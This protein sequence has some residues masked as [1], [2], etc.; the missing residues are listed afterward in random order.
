MG[1]SKPKI[2]IE[3]DPYLSIAAMDEEGARK[4]AISLGVKPDDIALVED[5]GPAGPKWKRGA[6]LFYVWD[7]KP[8]RPKRC[9]VCDDGA[10]ETKSKRC[11]K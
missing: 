10:C 4:T 3:R 11:G 6:R 7:S 9:P 1:Q 2:E 8:V 5:V